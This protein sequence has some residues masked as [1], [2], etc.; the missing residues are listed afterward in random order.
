M[1]IMGVGRR[2]RVPIHAP[3]PLAVLKGTG[4]LAGQEPLIGP[5]GPSEVEEEAGLEARERVSNRQL[6]NAMIL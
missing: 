2:C 5:E 4:V 3:T 1:K 6:R